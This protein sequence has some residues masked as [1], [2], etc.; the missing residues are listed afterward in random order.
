MTCKAVQQKAA[1]LMQKINAASS[2]VNEP[3]TPVATFWVDVYRLHLMKSMN[4]ST[5]NGY[6]KICQQHLSVEFQRYSLAEYKTH[7]ATKVMTKLA[8]AGLG[9]RTIAHIRSLASGMFRHATP[10][11]NRNQD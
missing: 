2:S 11:Q 7:H 6:S 3:D 4:A 8:D 1:T 5:L 10:W 9:V